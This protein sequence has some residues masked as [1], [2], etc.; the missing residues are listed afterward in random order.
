MQKLCKKSKKWGF[1]SFPRLVFVVVAVVV[2]VVGTVVSIAVIVI[3][4]VVIVV[5]TDVEHV[6]LGTLQFSTSVEVRVGIPSVVRLFVRYQYSRRTALRIFLIFCMNVPYH[7]GKK[8][9]RP[10]VR[11]KSGS[12]IIHENVS[13]IMVFGHF[14]RDYWWDLPKNAHEYSLDGSLW[15][16]IG[17][18]VSR[19]LEVRYFAY[20]LSQYA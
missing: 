1:W 16:C 11:E 8:R 3:V 12:L 20:W 14:F 4:V 15:P 5:I 6:P 19:S 10:F 7:K 18:W 13:K 17:C 2:I 9:T